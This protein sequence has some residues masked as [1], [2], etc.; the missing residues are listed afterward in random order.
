[1]RDRTFS[2]PHQLLHDPEVAWHFW[3]LL[4]NLADHL[5]DWHENDFIGLAQEE[6]LDWDEPAG[7]DVSAPVGQPFESSPIGLSAVAPQESDPVRGY[8]PQPRPE[9]PGPINEDDIP[10]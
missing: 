9:P 5:W 8:I 2:L 6:S 7:E 3:L 4:H 1:M 10:F